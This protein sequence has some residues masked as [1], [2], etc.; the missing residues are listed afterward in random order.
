MFFRNRSSQQDVE[1]FF[2]SPSSLNATLPFIYFIYFIAFCITVVSVVM[3]SADS[4]FISCLLFI[5]LG[6]TLAATHYFYHTAKIHIK[7]L[8]EQVNVFLEA[9]NV[10][11]EY[12]IIFNEHG[13]ITYSDPR[14]EEL[15]K[16]SQLKNC[17]ELELIEKVLRLKP[18]QIKKINNLI[19]RTDLEEEIIEYVKPYVLALKPFKLYGSK[20]ALTTNVLKDYS[21][22]KV[23]KFKE[24]SDF[25]QLV[26]ELSI[27]FYEL[28]QGGLILE[29]NEYL[30]R[31]LGYSKAELLKDFKFET[32]LEKQ[33]LTLNI[34]HKQFN[35]SFNGIVML[36]TK[37]NEKLNVFIVQNVTYGS[38]GKIE[39]IT[40]NIIKLKDNLLVLKNKG[41]EDSW[42]EY[43]WNSF[44]KE[45]P[46]PVA[47][48]DKNGVILRMNR[49][50]DNILPRRYLNKAFSDIFKNEDKSIIEQEL[51]SLVNTDK[52]PSSI[53]GLHILEND[54]IFDI[55]I[56]KIL[57]LD[58]NHY[59]FMTRIADITHEKELED[60]LNHSQRMQTIGQLVG[61]IAHDFNN[62]LTAITGFCDLLLLKHHAGDP[63][64]VNIQQIQQSAT[65]ATSLVRRLLAFSR[66]QT[67]NPEVV[68]LSE[69]FSDFT[70]VIHRLIGGEVHYEL[71]VSPN[72]WPV[73]IDAV[74][75]EQVILNLAVNARHAIGEKG[76]II[77]DVSNFSISSK[78]HEFSHYYN[79]SPKETIPSGD[80]VKISVKDSGTG[81]KKE[82]LG[83]IFE[84]FFTTKEEKSGTGLGLSTV[85]GI[86]RQSEGYILVDTE[87][88]SGST[89]VVLLKRHPMTEEEIEAYYSKQK[90]L[91]T[92]DLSPVNSLIGNETILLVEDEDAVRLYAKNALELKGY[93]VIEYNSAKKA[94]KD[95]K[96]YIDKVDLIITDVVMPEMT[97]PAFI[98]EVH[99]IAPDKKVIFISG[100]GED[101]FNEE[102][103][104]ARN[105]HLIAKPFSLKQLAQKVKEVITT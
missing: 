102:Y 48:L 28:D 103:G 36:N 29:V 85:F 24:E 55:Y 75:F 87:I 8:E 54:K 88:G 37:H 71:N 33:N 70:T 15:R 63:S 83:K 10:D 91:T 40:G 51:K 60:S 19:Y 84:P 57:D 42:I 34:K 35:E 27:G 18:S 86:V 66:K 47:V 64:F 77:I 100:Y 96:S 76:E 82:I 61:S 104:E 22:L 94:T 5:A 74:Q 39:K 17:S 43:S 56:G 97:G 14:F 73:M 11:S 41:I 93:N 49:S 78:K 38:N 16:I 20:V 68:F 21:I 44:F 81:I 105:F 6:V 3:Y 13:D 101:A 52:P 32:L 59:G 58:G 79:P 92:P 50:L 26:D 4:I 98:K 65:R 80:Y 95:L 23:K 99:S 31:I 1:G 9:L 62:L 72:T 25:S 30:A 90:E 89:F 69:L 45:S 46:Y 7:S 12:T 53:K 67:L 2:Q